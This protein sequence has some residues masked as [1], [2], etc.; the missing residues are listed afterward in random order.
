MKKATLTAVIMFFCSSAAFSQQW[1]SYTN[2]RPARRL[3]I[4]PG[5]QNLWGATPGGA[6]EFSC[7]DTVLIKNYTNIDGLPQI[8]VNDLAA[9]PQ[10]RIW[11]AT[12]GGGLAR[13]DTLS[14]SWYYCGLI[15][16]L[17]SDTV[18]AICCHGSYLLAGS[19]QGL[20]F[21]NG[22][23]WQGY[24][25]SQI[26]PGAMSINCLAILRDT[27]WMGTDAGLTKASLAEIAAQA[28]SWSRDSLTSLGSRQVLSLLLE[29]TLVLAGTAAGAARFNGT[30]WT[31]LVQ[32][33]GLEVRGILQ[34]GD[35]LMFATDSGMKLCDHG[36]WSDLSTG[37]PSAQTYSI[38]QDSGGR[39][40]CGTE[41]GI[42]MLDNGGWHPFKFDCLSTNSCFRVACDGS[43]NPYVINQF[44]REISYR[45]G[46]Q[47]H[48][49]NQTNTGMPFNILECAAFDRFGT[50]YVG[51]WGQG[52]FILTADENWHHYGS[53]APLSAQVVKDIL[54]V[55]DGV[56]LAQWDY[57]Y[58]D[59]LCF[60]S[61]SDTLFHTLWGPVETLRPNAL[62][63]GEQGELYVATNALGLY[64]RDAH[65]DWVNY[66]TANSGL[67][68]ISVSC[69]DWEQGGRLWV[70]T[71]EGLGVL[72]DSV[73]TRFSGE[74]LS[75]KIVS[76]K[77]DRSHNKWVGT[78][79]GL[80]LIS[81]DNRVV[82][83]T[84]QNSP[85]LSD[86]INQI[87]IAAGDVYGDR[88]FIATDKG[89][90][91]LHFSNTVN[92]QQPQ[93]GLAPNPYCPDREPFFYFYNLPS[94][95]TVRIYSLDG[96]MIKTFNGP[97]APAHILIVKK[98]DTGAKLVSGL[99][100]C[101]IS[102]P[103]FKSAVCKLAVVR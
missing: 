70:G 54:P 87:A 66:N 13:L 51:D 78:D 64:R 60:F 6:F 56:F 76:I 19:R 94:E 2:F 10:G 92:G 71:S 93:V 12:N 47:W 67:P 28:P 50:L 20:S 35:S 38:I 37:L 100:L 42:A 82:S 34:Q 52:L 96:R 1:T 29:D 14:K 48:F 65:G 30:V 75:P 91:V 79:K 15:D 72:Q 27:L 36:L 8:E 103:G 95:A 53:P 11:F 62:A 88:V 81:W 7:Q 57:Y 21:F 41:Q 49:Y 39:F 86:R 84:R 74:L 40:W 80:N 4:P 3:L 58:R 89:L 63:M 5:L 44:Q 25:L 33:N 31:A 97:Q 32:L 85:L 46:G 73:L 99:Y 77:T 24:L 45:I 98:A 101:H 68:N 9:D 22:N 55:P 102:A 90:S 69:L 59:P 16:G 18:T 83:F 17:V 26:F 23:A 61:Y 43:G